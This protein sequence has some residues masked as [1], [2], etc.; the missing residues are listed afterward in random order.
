MI[1][2]EVISFLKANSA[3]EINRLNNNREAS[4][5]QKNYYEHIIRNQNEY[6][7]TA[8]YILNN[9]FNWTDDKYN[10]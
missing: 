8:D 9:P 3:S 2:P 7:K 10:T 6:Q 4:F 5:W 1:L